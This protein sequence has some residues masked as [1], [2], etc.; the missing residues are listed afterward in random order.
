M[1]EEAGKLKAIV[2]G[3]LLT[4]LLMGMALTSLS[5]SL[6]Q[7]SATR[8]VGVQVGSWWE[9]SAVAEGNMTGFNAANQPD[10]AKFDVT[11]IS[12]TNVTLQTLWRY[13]NG[14]QMSLTGSV[15]V[16]N[17]SGD[18]AGLI[19][20]AGLNKGDQIYNGTWYLTG[21]QDESGATINDTLTRNYLGSNVEVCHWN[22]TRA[23]TSW[24]YFWL[25][26]TGIL[27]ESTENMTVVETDAYY[28][29]YL[30]VTITGY[31]PAGALTGTVTINPDGSISSPVPANITTRDNVTYTFTGNNYLPIV[32]N[33]S[34]IIINGNGY[35]L[36]AS[37]SNGYSLTGIKGV[38]IKN[39]TITNSNYGIYLED[40]S[41]NTLSGNNIT[42][43]KFG[44]YLNSSSSNAISGN[45]ITDTLYGVF[46]GS[47]SNS[48][49]ISGN[50]ITNTGYG[51]YLNSSSGDAISGNSITNTFDGVEL[52]SSSNNNTI[53]GNTITANTIDGVYLGSSSDN[54][55][56]GNNI[57]NNQFGVYLDSSS[58]NAISGN[59]ITANTYC[60]VE[61][62]SSSNSNAISG[63]VFVG[64]G[65]FVSHSHENIVLNNTVNGRPLVYL[66]NASNLPVAQAGQVVLV[67]CSRIRVQNLNLSQTTV[68]LELWNTNDT[69]AS[70][71]N[72]ANTFWGV[73]LDSS[74]SNGISGNNITNTDL[75]VELY[76]S[77]NNNTIS[78][79]TIT[80][81]TID[82][83][84]L[85]SSSDNTISGNNITANTE[86]GVFI[87]SSSNNNAISGNTITANTIDGVY[88]GS[89]SD[90]T[91]SGNTITAS[92]IDGVYLFSSSN[93]TLSGNNITNNQFGVY[94]FS[95][96]DNT[97][98]GNSI[99]ANGEGIQLFYSSS[100]RIFHND[101]LSNGVQASEGNSANTWDGGYPSGGNYWS[102]YRMRYPG[103]AENDSSGIWNM[104]YVIDANNTDRYPLVAV[105]ESFKVT[106]NN[107][108]Y[109]VN[110]VSNSTLSNFNFSATAKTLTFNVTGAAGT[111]GF[112]RVAIPLSFMSGEWTVTINGTPI[113]YS[114]STDSNYTYIYFTYHHSTE[115]VKITSTSAVRE[116]QPLMFLPMFMI[117]TL[118]AAIILK[119]KRK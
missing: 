64:C 21:G 99:T 91:I 14:T 73:Y 83:V 7:V 48:N 63:N 100:N 43:N 44:V 54:T 82:G 58:G 38:T 3:V 90:N 96:S 118:L 66:E 22:W 86:E 37:G 41:N 39:T 98:S 61:L 55:I 107:E 85:S 46:L 77:S 4:L 56:S 110:T 71:N 79:N 53:S 5:T 78:G 92:T 25:R 11:G 102:D 97:I 87:G 32:V 49:A 70:R 1:L 106:W 50:S 67:N 94:F 111:V 42:N 31:F 72:I 81:S 19:I 8:T 9:V 16:E 113:S 114:T 13:A 119:R 33:R 84:C 60:G 27:A 69:L 17:G 76:S 30:D 62:G 101:F 117:V 95:S 88:L 105:F 57:T 40:S 2:S 68:G 52:G 12:G 51:V 116:F 104:S 112:C 108:T 59:E 93:N 35:T 23:S 103:A 74:S 89:S 65:L 115:T 75:G 80:A 34:N 28:W 36:N 20:A 24:N 10:Y 26:D 109:S 18:L 15:D 6:A 29:E 47:S 45:S